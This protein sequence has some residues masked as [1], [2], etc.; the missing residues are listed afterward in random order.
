[1]PPADQCLG[2]NNLP[3]VD[4]DDRLVVHLELLAPHRRGQLGP[5]SGAVHHLGMKVVVINLYATLSSLLCRIQSQIR[6]P[7]QLGEVGGYFIPAAEDHPNA[8]RSQNLFTLEDKWRA[9][10]LHDPL[11]EV[12]RL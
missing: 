12:S 5:L 8:R 3:S 1:M 2:P 9:E 10:R 11:G 4:Q 6:A 7:K